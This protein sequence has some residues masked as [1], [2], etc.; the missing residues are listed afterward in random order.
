VDV[1]RAVRAAR[2]GSPA[3][4]QAS[5]VRRAPVVAAAVAVL[6]V[7]GVAG[8]G[9]GGGGG[10]GGSTPAA[11]TDCALAGAGS[12][13]PGGPPVIDPGDG[14][15][16]Q[17]EPDPADFVERI[18]HPYR[19]L[20]PGTRWVYDGV[21]DGERERTE[22]VVT[23]DRRD[24]MGISAVVVEDT[25]YV[26]DEMVAQSLDAYAQDRD[27]NVWFL[28]EESADYEN[29][30][31]VC[32]AGS[33]EAGVDGARPGIVMPAQPTEGDAYRQQYVAGEAEDLARIARLGE[34]RT[35]GLGDY[36]DVLVIEE[37]S[38]LEPDVTEE[39]YYAPGVGKIFEV[40]T[41]G[42]DATSEL[43]ELTA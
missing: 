5:A 42:G 13:E 10:A 12:A 4:G 40:Q 38:P 1:V 31:V 17:P 11:G 28:G 29:G 20:L 26:G 15:D 41:A 30:E 8:C 32:T 9:D 2:T 39:K 21:S 25:T 35:I 6:L 34:T 43:I 14:G 19:P 37:W 27:G 3:S 36:Q 18:D 33:W 23:S 7:G 22:V 24:I 16:Y